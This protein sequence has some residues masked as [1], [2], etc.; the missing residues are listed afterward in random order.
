M[1]DTLSLEEAVNTESQQMVDDA[2]VVIVDHFHFETSV[3]E[4]LTIE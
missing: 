4:S 2:R 3:E 1:G